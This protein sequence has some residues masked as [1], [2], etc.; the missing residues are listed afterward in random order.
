MKYNNIYKNNYRITSKNDSFYYGEFTFHKNVK[1][2]C[3]FIQDLKNTLN[4]IGNKN[5]KHLR[6]ELDAQ[7]NLGMLLKVLEF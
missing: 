4:E 3:F 2:F 6:H 1:L 7:E 5:H